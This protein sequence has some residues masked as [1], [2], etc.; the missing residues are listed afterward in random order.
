VQ[1]RTL[2]AIE[3]FYADEYKILLSSADED[4]LYATENGRK[5]FRVEHQLQ[6]MLETLSIPRGGRVLDFGAA[7]GAMAKALQAND[8]K[9]AVFV[10]DVSEQYRPFWS[11]GIDPDRCAIKDIP[12][13]WRGSFDVVMSFFVLEHIPELG[14]VLESVRQQ[15]RPGGDFYFLVPNMYANIADFVVVDHA[16]HFSELSLELLLGLHG[17]EPQV[18]D[19][20]RHQSAFVVHARRT[21][22]APD[23]GPSADRKVADLRAAVL[24]MAHTIDD[25]ATRTR[26]F[27]GEH[28][29]AKAAIYGSGFY[30]AYVTTLLHHPDR[31]RCYVDQ[32]PHRHGHQLFGKPIVTPRDLPADIDTIYVGLNPRVARSALAA[33]TEWRDRNLEFNYL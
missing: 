14:F 29:D 28:P 15:L 13:E 21:D 3:Q 1:T 19:A 17:F 26:D 16:N 11:N 6:T 12:D 8:P 2:D 25:F 20:T 31:I 32:N 22:A 24:A 4:Q 7:K 10:F 9:L 27:E 30:G 5:V 33:V 18:I 23:T